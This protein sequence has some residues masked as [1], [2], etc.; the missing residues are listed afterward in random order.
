M[1]GRGKDGKR[2]ANTGDTG[3]EGVNCANDL[4]SRGHGETGGDREFAEVTQVKV[5]GTEKEKS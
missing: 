1:Q 2:R 5:A 3:P 4:V